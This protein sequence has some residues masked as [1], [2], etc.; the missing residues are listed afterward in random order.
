MT[1]AIPTVLNFRET[2]AAEEAAEDALAALKG[3]AFCILHGRMHPVLRDEIRG[4]RTERMV[5]AILA[6]ELEY[7]R[8]PDDCTW[9]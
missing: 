9:R 3:R 1:A 8:H 7:G 6:D 5:R 4:A 2:I